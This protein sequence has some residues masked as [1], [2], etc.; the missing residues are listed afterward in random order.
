MKKLLSVFLAL[1]LIGTCL[2]VFSVPA[3]AATSGTCG[4]NAKWKISGST[5]TISGSGAME[6]YIY[7][8]YE[9]PGNE[10]APWR[11]DQTGS[12]PNIKKIVIKSG[13]TRIGDNAFCCLPNVTS[14]SIPNTVTSIGQAAFC[15][16]KKLSTVTIPNSVTELERSTFNRCSGLT[17]VTLSNKLTEIPGYMFKECGKLK[18][19]TLPDGITKI[20]GSAFN[21]CYA[22][23]SIKIPAGVTTIEGNAFE[24]CESLKTIKLPDNLERIGPFAFSASGLT[25]IT[26]PQKVDHIY[27]NTLGWCMSLKEVYFTGDAPDFDSGAFSC[28]TTTVYYPWENKT[29]TKSV[30]KDYDGTLTWVALDSDGKPV[31]HTHS[32]DSDC[33][34][35]CN[36]CD[37]TRET[38][39]IY[40]TN[41]RRDPENHWHGCTVCGDKIDLAAHTFTPEEPDVCTVCGPLKVEGDLDGSCELNEDDVIYLLQHVLMPGDFLLR[42]PADYDKNDIIN[43]DDVV[44]LLQH[45]LMPGDF[46]LT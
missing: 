27:N 14:V 28:T 43:E 6:D 8:G 36:D 40:G 5:L 29:W 25:S 31:V 15:D 26:I 38:E 44:Y 23:E 13:I 1:T 20:D 17:S 37:Y 2:W 12:N 30:R 10:M 7:S 46:P 19:V 18:K 32:F 41:W 9:L 33:D 4:E 11:D 3:S 24:Y 34:P 22:L 42:Q 45:L 39:H 21:S 16:I 35:D